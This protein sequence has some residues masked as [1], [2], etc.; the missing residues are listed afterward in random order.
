MARQ[1]IVRTVDDGLVVA[2]KRRA[3]RHGRPAE[4]EHRE[5]LRAGGRGAAPHPT[6][7]YESK[8]LRG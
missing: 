1:L 3:T 7:R 4:A 8:T 5:I 6:S 2:S